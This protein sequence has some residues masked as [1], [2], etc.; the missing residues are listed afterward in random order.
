MSEAHAKQKLSEPPVDAL[1]DEFD[2]DDEW[3]PVD[4]EGLH[5]ALD[6]SLKSAERGELI[7]AEEVIRELEDRIR[8]LQTR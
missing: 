2:D 7:P 5:K 4:P 3:V 6:E 8:R 1:E